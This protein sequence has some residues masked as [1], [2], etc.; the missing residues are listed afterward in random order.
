MNTLTLHELTGL[1]EESIRE[2]IY[3]FYISNTHLDYTD[4]IFD[5]F[6]CRELIELLAALELEDVLEWDEGGYFL[7]DLSGISK[8][9]LYE[10]ISKISPDKRQAIFDKIMEEELI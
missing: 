4:D 1:S 8:I 2:I 9:F 7:G 10:A 3:I 6:K 5:K